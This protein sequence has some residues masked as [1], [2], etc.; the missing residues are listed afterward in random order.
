MSIPLGDMRNGFAL[1][2]PSWKRPRNFKA[3]NFR[4]IEQRHHESLTYPH[5][6]MEL[7]QDIWLIIINVRPITALNRSDSLSAKGAMCVERLQGSMWP[8]WNEEIRNDEWMVR[9][10][11]WAGNT[12]EGLLFV[13]IWSPALSVLPSFSGSLWI[14]HLGLFIN[15]HQVL[16]CQHNEKSVRY[17]GDFILDKEKKGILLIFELEK[18]SYWLIL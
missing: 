15:V 17:K 11:D 8:F 9:C 18:S 12:P 5:K 13:P 7:Q 4:Q 16:E 3:F 2:L 14:D 1:K 10:S 6:K